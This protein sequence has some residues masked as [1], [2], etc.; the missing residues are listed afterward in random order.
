MALLAPGGNG[1]KWPFSPGTNNTID[2]RYKNMGGFWGFY[3][4]L[5]A[6]LNISMMILVILACIKY[7]KQNK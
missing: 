2:E 7:L 4:F 3:S 5:S 6:V 1:Q